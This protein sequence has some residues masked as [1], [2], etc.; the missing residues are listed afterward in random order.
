MELEDWV[1]VNGMRHRAIIQKWQNGQSVIR[2]PENKIVRLLLDIASRKG[3]YDLNQLAVD[4]RF[5]TKEETLEF[6]RL[7]SYSLSGYAELFMGGDP[8]DGDE[9]RHNWVKTMK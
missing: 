3:M 8:A 6:H 7:I 5:Y 1:E 2:F 4:Q 9:D